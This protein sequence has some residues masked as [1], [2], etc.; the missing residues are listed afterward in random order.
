TSGKEN[1][2]VQDTIKEDGGSSVNQDLTVHRIPSGSSSQSSDGVNP[3]TNTDDFDQITSTQ[4]SINSQ[5]SLW[6][7]SSQ[8]TY[9]EEEGGDHLENMNNKR[10]ALDT[11]LQSCGL[12][13]V[14]KQLG[15]DW[16]EASD[17]TKS[18]YISSAKSIFQ[19]VVNVLAPGQGSLLLDALLKTASDSADTNILQFLSKAYNLSTDWG[20]QRQILSL[21]AHAYTYNQLI[22]FIPTLTKYRYTAAR[23]HAITRGV[24]QQVQSSSYTREGLSDHQIKHFIDFVMS[25]C[26]MTDSP[27]LETKLKLSSGE[28]SQVP[29]IILNSVRARVVEQYRSFCLESEVE[30]VASDRSYMRVLEAIEPKVRKSMKGLDNFA[31][32]GAGAID[33]LK[34]IVTELGRLLKGVEWADDIVQKLAN[35]KQYLK[36]DYKMHVA[37]ESEI[38]DHCSYYALSSKA[39]E[40]QVTCSHPHNQICSSCHSLTNTIE[41][42]KNAADEAQFEDEDQRDNI[43]YTLAQS[44]KALEE[45]K[46]HILRSVNQDRARSDILE[47]IGEDQV[48]LERDWAM[49]FLPMMYRESQSKWF[50][51]RGLN[52]HMTVGTFKVNEDLHSHTI[53]H[54]FDNANQDATTSNSILKDSV[55]RLQE[56]N[57]KLKE[58]FIRSDNAG[59]FHGV[60]GVFGIPCLNRTNELKI[61]QRDFADPQ[62]SKSICDR[63]AAHIKGS[64]RKYVDEGNNVTTAR[65][66]L[67]A[68][69]NSNIKNV[70]VVYALP[71]SSGA[72]KKNL[73]IKDISLLNNF[74]YG[75][76]HVTCHRQYRIGRGVEFM[77]EEV[78]LYN[79][80]PSIETMTSCSTSTF[81]KPCEPGQSVVID[82]AQQIPVDAEN[83]QTIVEECNESSLIFTCPEPNCLMSFQKYGYL[84]K[85]LDRGNHK[86]K[87]H[88]NSLSDKAKK[89]FVD[90]IE[91]KRSTLL[92]KSSTT[93]PSDK[94]ILERGWALKSK[95]I[96]RRFSKEQTN[97]LREIFEKGEVTGY[98][99]DAEEVSM[100]MRTVKDNDGKRRFC[101]QE[102]LSLAQIASYFSRLS[103]E[104]RKISLSSY[105]EEDLV[106]EDFENNAMEIRNLATS[107]K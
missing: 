104:K 61:V 47:N 19:E 36:L 71:P 30:N 72:E 100:K 40:H 8:D 54:V 63:R 10:K 103:L 29:Q 18:D 68:V 83:T 56:K 64:I 17:R 55:E 75:H 69:M 28:V 97:F 77:N 88:V 3:S 41:Q 57:S 73:K 12:S 80:F 52:W 23:K 34:K 90:Q 39:Y 76:S 44:V 50:G 66:F 87:T 102:F 96:A 16:N 7:P 24:G 26:I 78:V 45:W 32:D 51:K 6:L 82:H 107:A 59:C 85:H 15:T 95:R 98:K 89:E 46:K 31:A 33:D 91:T 48:L 25:P 11:F 81:V 93:L 9:E 70:E 5:G 14:K 105:E 106:A 42:I 49:K 99:C 20:T 38:P 67:D 4:V 27:F 94:I 21:F 53:V 101:Q 84:S 60:E 37:V 35:G 22:A 92:Q 65:E 62:G 58:V 13:P 86:T 74:R 1:T 79:I 2:V 43:Q